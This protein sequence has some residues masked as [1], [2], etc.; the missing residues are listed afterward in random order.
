MDG[1]NKKRLLKALAKGY[2]RCTVLTAIAVAAT[3]IAAGVLGQAGNSPSDLSFVW[4]AAVCY[5]LSV[6]F[7]TVQIY[8]FGEGNDSL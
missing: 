3:V 6:L 2:F 8:F 1:I 5:L 7:D 4:K